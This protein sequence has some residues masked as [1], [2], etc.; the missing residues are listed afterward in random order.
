MISTARSLLAREREAFV[1]GVERRRSLLLFHRLQAT[2]IS[3]ASV[4][5]AVWR[6][7]LFGVDF[8]IQQRAFSVAWN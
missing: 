5:F 6:K 8:K 3:G 7:F 4:P 1:V 2:G